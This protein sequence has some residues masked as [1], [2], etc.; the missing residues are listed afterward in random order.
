MI[1][2]LLKAG[3]PKILAWTVILV[4]AATVMD[5]VTGHDVSLAAL[6]II[7]MM[8]GAVVLRP[9]GIAAF[10][11]ICSYIR[12]LFDVPGSSMELVLRFVF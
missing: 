6:Y 11:I 3:K 2:R 4:I 7:P 9:A 8:P 10:A 5:S 1:P 12:F